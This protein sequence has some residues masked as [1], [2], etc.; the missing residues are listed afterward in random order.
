[1]GGVR[2][3]STLHLLVD[4]WDEV[5]RGLQ[6]NRA[7]VTLTS[8]DYAKAFNRLSFQHCLARFARKGASTPVIELL[9]T[10]LSNRRM[11]VRVGEEWL[12][13]RPVNG[14]VPQGSI[15][16]VFLFNMAMD[17]LDGDLNGDREVEDEEG[18]GTEVS[19]TL[20]S[21]EDGLEAPEQPVQHST[22]LRLET[23][24]ESFHET[25]V[26]ARPV[27]ATGRYFQLGT[28]RGQR[29]AQR[30]IAYLSEEE[31]EVLTEASKRNLK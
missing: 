4:M 2:G 15:L 12:V 9:A 3:C 30:R 31:E 19:S 17:D 7:A 8:I 28:T 22:P 27:A 18:V 5:V 24:Q 16:E 11:S 26:R 10:F 20:M 1:M 13:P 14:G 21:D 29:A 6:D 25:P 23:Q